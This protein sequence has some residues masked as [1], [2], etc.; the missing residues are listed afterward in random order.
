MSRPQAD[1]ETRKYKEKCNSILAI[2]P[3]IRYAGI[4]NRFG[5]TLAGGLRKGVVPLLKQ[6]EARNEYF[7]EATRNQL[8]K[9]FERS[10]GKTEYTFTENEKVKILTI[11]SE[12]HFYYITMEKDT[13]ANEVARIIE[14][15]RK[16]VR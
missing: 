16:L 14:E 8:R 11:A 7:I 15:A 2:S 10:I 6:D 9:N 5:R 13:P 12:E 1:P 4:M 3:R